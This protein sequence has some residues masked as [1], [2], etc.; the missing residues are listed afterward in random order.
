M[1][2]LPKRNGGR[3]RP[4]PVLLQIGRRRYSAA[5]GNGCT[6]ICTLPSARRA[7]VTVPSTSAK[8]VWSRPRP[9][10]LPGCHLVPRWRTRMLPG[11]TASPPNFLTPR[12]LPAVSR[13]LRE[14]PPAF[15]CAM[16]GA[17]GRRSGDRD[18]ADAHD[19]QQ[20]P[21]AVAAAVVLAAA[22]LVDDDLLALGLFQHRAGD[23]RTGDGGRA[24]DRVVAADHQ[25]LGE[26]DRIA[27]LAG[28]ALDL[29]HL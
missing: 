5:T 28:Q 16:V 2:G 19:R 26:H 24:D 25:H 14:L 13:P 4:T 10:F 15:L 7:N 27:G 6:E 12:R 1:R 23:G 29:D 22:L 18:V 17:P 8:M 3:H 21:V 11:I 20:L 9:T